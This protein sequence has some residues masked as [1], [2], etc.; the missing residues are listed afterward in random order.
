VGTT[1][2]NFLRTVPLAALVVVFCSATLS[3]TS[4]G[5]LWALLSGSVC[6]GIG[7]VVWY[8]ALAGLTATRAA[9]VQL[10]VPVI[11]ALGG[12]VFLSEVLTLRL[13]IAA[14]A[15]LGGVA[16]AVWNRQPVMRRQERSR[17]LGET[18][19]EAQEHV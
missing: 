18:V 6:S 3:V 19:G 4:K 14:A 8:G 2:A 1:A 7:Y 17:S 15:I 12:V 16:I 10:S 5:I 9:A 11:A 13:S